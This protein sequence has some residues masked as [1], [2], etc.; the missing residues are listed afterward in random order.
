MKITADSSAL[1]VIDMQNGF[2]EEG[3]ALRVPA[4]K[5]TVPAIDAL[6]QRARKAGVKII[7]VIREYAADGSDVEWPRRKDLENRGLLGV[8]APGTTGINSPEIVTGLD[9]KDEDITIV[10]PRFSS[11]LKTDLDNIL[12]TA[13]IGTVI[14]T[15][16]ATPNCIRATAF[17][18]ISYDYAA[19]VAEDCCSSK[20]DEIQRTNMKDMANIGCDIVNSNDILFE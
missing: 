5:A 4:A 1:L 3:A 9:P 17:D 15:G 2:V 6:V 10:K 18:A 20:T 8:M 13:G 7:W 16:T 19:I 12:K 14:I 11:F